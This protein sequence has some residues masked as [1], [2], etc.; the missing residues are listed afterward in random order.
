[1]VCYHWFS[2][3][4]DLGWGLLPPV[5]AVLVSVS[6]FLW[7]ILSLIKEMA[8]VRMSG[9]LS[10]FRAFKVLSAHKNTFNFS[11]CPPGKQV[12]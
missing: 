8:N 9:H 2:V 11:K 10:Y 3:A 5:A 6:D 1:M 12:L 4:L 7:K